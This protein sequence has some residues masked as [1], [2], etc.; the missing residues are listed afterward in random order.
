MDL[1][2]PKGVELFTVPVTDTVNK[3]IYKKIIFFQ[4]IIFT[5]N[6]F[7][8]IIRTMKR[9]IKIVEE[10]NDILEKNGIQCFFSYDTKNDRYTFRTYDGT[11]INN[12]YVTQCKIYLKTENQGV[13]NE[14]T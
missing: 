12:N 9:P 10:L 11:L 8:Y 14:N 6:I 5:K 13:N 7:E 2:G 4:K 1:D 3:I